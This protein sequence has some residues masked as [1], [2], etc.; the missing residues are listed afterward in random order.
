MN[1]T[2][3]TQ[4]PSSREEEGTKTNSLKSYMIDFIQSSPVQ[5]E[6]ENRYQNALINNPNINR[7][8]AEEVFL[9]TEPA[10]ELF[11]K[12]YHEKGNFNFNLGDISLDAQIALLNYFAMIDCIMN[13]QR[14]GYYIS[15]R[16]EIQDDD[17]RRA[18][19]H[20]AV[21]NQLHNDGI[22]PHCYPW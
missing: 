8:R 10:K 22:S 6:V 5:E 1:S 11:W 12:Y 4:S 9:R 7:E 13:K 3:Q 18:G 17:V 21:A 20:S 2:E 15:N 14:L 19:T 16:E